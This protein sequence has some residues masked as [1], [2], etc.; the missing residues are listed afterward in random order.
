MEFL[1]TGSRI[2]ANDDDRIWH[3]LTRSDCFKLVGFKHESSGQEASSSEVS[4]FSAFQRSRGIHRAYQ[5][6]S[7]H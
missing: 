7:G 2:R 1:V 6:V 3:D 4:R 5:G